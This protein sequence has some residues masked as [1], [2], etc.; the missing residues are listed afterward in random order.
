MVGRML[1]FVLALAMAGSG[2]AEVHF[3]ASCSPHASCGDSEG[4]GWVL[5]STALVPLTAS[6]MDKR[7]SARPFLTMASL[8]LGLGFVALVIWV[9]AALSNGID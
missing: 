7:S 2:I 8:T 5:I 6:V 1:L 9:V 3:A 4:L